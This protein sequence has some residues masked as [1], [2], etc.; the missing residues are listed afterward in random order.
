MAQPETTK[1]SDT[2]TKRKIRTLSSG[3]VPVFQH[4]ERGLIFL[5]LRCYNYWDFPKG[6]VN[7]GEEPIDAALRELKE[8]TTLE[9][10]DFKWGREFKETPAYAGGKVARY[11]IGEVTRIE[12]DL[13][14]NP[15]L[16]RAEH[17]EYRW[18]TGSEAHALL[19]ARVRPILE[20]A[21]SIMGVRK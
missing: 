2:R 6:G 21:Q 4:P 5:L 3:I 13:P 1:T 16:G 18:V 12:V 14:I 11:Y 7:K 17:H 10:A 20:W 9:T 19:N 8:E 15:L